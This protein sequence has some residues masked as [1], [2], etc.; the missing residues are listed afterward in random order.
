MNPFLAGV[1]V[2]IAILGAL[3]TLEATGSTD[4]GLN[5]LWGGD[6]VQAA[7]MTP[8]VMATVPLEP[9]ERVTVPKLWNREKKTL[10]HQYMSKDL[11]SERSFFAQ[12]QEVVGR[13]LARPKAPNQAFVEEDFLPKGSPEGVLGLIPEGMVSVPVDAEKVQGI[14]LLGFR[15]RFDLRVML[16]MDDSVR[17]MAEEV[18][19]KRGYA[20][21][22]DRLRLAAIAG[23]PKQRLLAQNGMVV[24]PT[25]EEDGVVVVAL[26]PDDVDS[27]IDALSA[28]STIFCTSRPASQ[29]AQ[30]ARV[31]PEEIDPMEE[32]RWVLDSSREVEVIQGGRTERMVVPV[33]SN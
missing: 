5:R 8:V 33:G 10:N 12:P 14:N 15:D 9:G 11:V 19:D 18:L 25:K 24:R 20:S 22:A 13:V 23:G 4:L 3:F 1:L 26:H 16:A 7:N 32:Y 31:T 17:E 28:D 2:L 27:T 30:V 6:E 29:G 21:E